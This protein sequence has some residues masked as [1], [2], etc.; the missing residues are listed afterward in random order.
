MYDFILKSCGTCEILA[1]TSK[2]KS[3]II[4]RFWGLFTQQKA[5]CKGQICC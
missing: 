4:L 1:L 3:R 5:K 2:M